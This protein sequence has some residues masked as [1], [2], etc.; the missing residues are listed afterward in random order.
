MIRTRKPLRPRWRWLIVRSITGRSRG[1]YSLTPWLSDGQNLLVGSACGEL[2][3]ELLVKI[4]KHTRPHS[5]DTYT[6]VYSYP[7]ALAQVCHHWRAVVLGAPTLWSN[8]NIMEY[9]TDKSKVAAHTYLE[10]SKMCPLFLTW[11]SHEQTNI[12]VQEV[13]NNLVIPFA[14]RWQRI[15]LIAHDEEA[16]NALLTAMETLDFPN[17]RDIEISSYFMRLSP[18]ELTLAR[19]AP[20]LRRCRLDSFPSLPP[21]PSR[22]V[23]LDYLLTALNAEPVILDPLLDFLPHVAH[24]VEHLRFRSINFQVLVTPRRSRILLQQLKSLLVEDSHIVMNHVLTPNLTYLAVIHP[25]NADAHKI[26]GMLDGFSAP[27]L[28]TLQF[29]R[30]PLLPLLASH[31]LPSMFPQLESVIIDNCINEPA[32]ISLLVPP[33][34]K[35][36]LS[37]LQSGLKYRQVK[38][39][40]PKLKE[41]TMSVSDT[42]H[43][44]SLQA[45]IRGRFKNGNRSLRKVLLPDTIP[46]QARSFMKQWLRERKIELVQYEDGKWLIPTPPE[47]QDDINE[48][49][50]RYF[51]DNCEWC[52]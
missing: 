38:N 22:L 24:S 42:R 31:H 29:Y 33:G 3:T 32:F 15:T 8:I 44:I 52:R 21:L 18:S 7:V 19:S 9:T 45:A 46:R 27:K 4:F 23:V 47:F 36:P 20:L 12:N 17:L 28:H 49:E 50:F 1:S 13:I 6:G 11:F 26:A 43:L 40:F 51:S 25:Q 39:P 48:E 34:L 2:P 35:K 37:D 16:P 5:P 41:L 14:E 10:L 30:T